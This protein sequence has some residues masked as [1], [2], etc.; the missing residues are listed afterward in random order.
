MNRMFYV[1]K[2]SFSDGAEYVGQ[3]VNVKRRIQKHIAQ[4]VNQQLYEHLKNLEYSVKII[5]EHEKLSYVNASEKKN[6]LLLEKPLNVYVGGIP[7]R[8]TGVKPQ[9]NKQFCN[10]WKNK[11]RGVVY[12]RISGEYICGWCER[13]LDASSFHTDKSRSVGIGSRCKDCIHYKSKLMR[14]SILRS[15]SSSEGYF[16]AKTAAKKIVRQLRLE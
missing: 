6:I 9:M 13:M 4:P 8:R 7:I 16:R 2:I 14:D 10:K 11:K 15:G 12:P 3:T 1:Y 5:Y